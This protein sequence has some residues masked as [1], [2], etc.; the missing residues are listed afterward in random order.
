M[1]AARAAAVGWSNTS[2]PVSSTPIALPSSFRT[3]TAPATRGRILK[4]SPTKAHVA[5]MGG[6]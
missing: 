5:V 6:L 2:V 4:F 1:W 3:S